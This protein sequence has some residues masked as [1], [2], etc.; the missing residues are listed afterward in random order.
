[1]RFSGN[2]RRVCQLSLLFVNYYEFSNDVHSAE[3]H[4]AAATA[5][6]T[7]QPCVFVTSSA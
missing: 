2:A 3:S 7:G 1:M 6:T 5:F 4:S